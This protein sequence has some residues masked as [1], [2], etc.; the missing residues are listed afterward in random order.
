MDKRLEKAKKEILQ[1]NFQTERAIIGQ[2]TMVVRT[3]SNPVA[4]VRQAIIR[5]IKNML[6]PVKEL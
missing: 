1:D 3:L 2:T 5:E 4:S 6:N